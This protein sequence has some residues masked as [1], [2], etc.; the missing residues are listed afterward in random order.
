MAATTVTAGEKYCLKNDSQDQS[1]LNVIVETFNVVT[2]Q[3]YSSL[4]VT[5]T[6]KVVLGVHVT[7][8][9]GTVMPIGVKCNLTPVAGVLTITL[10]Q[11]PGAD[12]VLAALANDKNL[13]I[14]LFGLSY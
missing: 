12:G 5:T 9:S 13:K 14:L 1:R 6:L 11:D 4:S 8:L 2:D 7:L 3:T 10:T